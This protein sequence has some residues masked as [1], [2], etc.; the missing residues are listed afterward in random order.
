MK[1]NGFL[2]FLLIAVFGLVLI[3]CKPQVPPGGDDDDDDDVE[4][5]LSAEVTS[6]TLKVEETITITPV[7]SN[8]TET[9][10]VNFVSN[11]QNIATVDGN[12]VVSGISEG[13][14]T[15]TVSLDLYPTIKVDISI[16]VEPKD[17]EPPIIVPPLTLDGPSEIFVGESF[18]LTATDTSS[19]DN[20]VFWE[21]SDPKVLKVDQ[22][23][24][25]T[26]VS[27]GT[28]TI[29]ILSYYTTDFL[30]LEITVIVP[31][32]VSVEIDS[33]NLSQ[34]TLNSV[35]KLNARVLPI[36]ATQDVI[37]ESDDERIALVDT[38]GRV[39]PIAAG[40]VTMTA[41]VKNTELKASITFKVEPTPMEIFEFIHNESPINKDITVYGFET[42]GN[43]SYQLLGSVS[44]YLNHPLNVTTSLVSTSMSNRPGIIKTSTEYITIHD[45]GSAAASANSAAHDSYVRNGGG[46]ASW[47]YTVGNDGIFNQIPDNEVAYHAGDGSRTY[48]LNDS[49]VLATSKYKP[50]ITI[51]PDGYYALNG[52]KTIVIAPKNGDTILTTAHINDNGIEVVRGDNGNWFIG[53]T[54]YNTTYKLISNHGGNRNSIG[55]ESCVNKG[56][57]VF[58]TWQL[59]AKLTAKLLVEQNLTIENVVQHHYFS[60][61]DCPMTMRHAGMWT[62]FLEMVEAEYLVRTFLDGYT[63]TI[64]S[65]S[66]QYIS[67]TGRIIALPD[68][69]LRVSYDVVI[70]NS[71]GYNAQKTF[72][73]NLPAK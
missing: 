12:G 14:T 5:T 25:I 3:G 1:K 72:Y 66:P 39:T 45:T 58:L 19:P 67:N 64:T 51:T 24:K 40:E 54:Y 35:F 15:I 46:G 69:P 17:D 16:T 36:G 22:T 4:P 29:T 38:G 63:I 44:K 2:L 23:G 70:T 60:G 59:L 27:G 68:V 10:Q 6:F 61:K 65:N 55:I 33:I 28:A 7:I 32:P 43:Y 11:N 21:S 41:T 71:S 26:G 8:T 47:H 9:L 52:T 18:T 53:D 62:Y 73:T 57:D 49:G 56:S 34:I 20:T 37:W 13:A 50:I 42:N 48:N 31:D 30:E